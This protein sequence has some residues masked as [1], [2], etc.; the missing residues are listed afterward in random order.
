MYPFSRT[1]VLSYS[2]MREETHDYSQLHNDDKN[3]PVNYL[4]V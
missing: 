1:S 2:A 3:L 4:E